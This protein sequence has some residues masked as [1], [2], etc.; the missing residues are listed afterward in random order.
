MNSENRWISW[1]ILRI[2]THEDDSK[3]NIEAYFVELRGTPAWAGLAAFAIIPE[4]A[5]LGAFVGGP[6]GEEDVEELRSE[7][8]I[9]GLK[10]DIECILAKTEMI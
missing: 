8:S 5:S 10:V 2:F 7:R 1:A 9:R 4:M 3:W 6:L